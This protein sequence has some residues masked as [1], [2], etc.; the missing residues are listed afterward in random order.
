MGDFNCILNSN[1]RIGR[2][3]IVREMREFR[4][5]IDQCELQELKSSGAFYTWNSKQQGTDRVYSRIDIVLTNIDWLTQL[6]ASE[7]HFMNEGLYDHCPAII[8]WDKGSQNNTRSFKYFNIWKLVPEYKQ[9]VQS[10]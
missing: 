7:V 3:A 9:K 5:C 2:A 8:K 10:N 1:E 6:P 4:Q